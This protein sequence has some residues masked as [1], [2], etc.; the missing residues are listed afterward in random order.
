MKYR[1]SKKAQQILDHLKKVKRPLS[2]SSIAK[3]LG[4]NGETVRSLLGSLRQR[5]LIED[6]ETTHVEFYQ[7]TS[8]GQHFAAKGL[9]EIRL[10]KLLAKQGGEGS[11]ESIADEKILKPSEQQLAL[12]WARRNKW[13]SVSK[14]DNQTWMKLASKASYAINQHPLQIA[15]DS[16]EE[17][18]VLQLDDVNLERKD[19]RSIQL[20]LHK[21][22]LAELVSRQTI[23]VSITSKGLQALETSLIDEDLIRDLSP[24]L[25]KSEAWK[26]QDFMPYNLRAPTSPLYPGKKHPFVEFIDRLKRVL[27][28]LGFQEAKGPLVE[29]E[30]WN[31]D[32]LFMPQDHV[33]REV[34]DLYHIQTPKGPGRIIDESALKRVAKTHENGWKTGSTGWRYPYSF[35]IARR[36]VMRSQTTS[37]S[38]RFL[39]KHK[40]PPITM[41]SIDRNFRPEKFDATHS[42]EFIQ[43]EG[44]IG[45]EGLTLRDLM[46][47]LQSIA[48]GVGVEQLKFKP[49]FFP[50]T[51]PSVEGFVFI[52]KIGWKELGGSGI[53]RPEVTLPFGI[54]FPVLAWGLGADRLA[55][56]AL[57]ISDIRELATRN[58]GQ[59]RKT[60][61][62]F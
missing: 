31:N 46:G 17:S 32:A 16:A 2:V 61:M 56:A 5:K 8:E 22:K 6:K 59:L 29:T 35:D 15:L 19:L 45:G 3:S 28:G 47:Y 20:N 37:V 62:R 18:G 36:L 38:M 51:E 23:T 9:P 39:S 58:L 60:S 4:L 21:R 54:D 49:G 1:L 7:L 50:F 26:D 57:G 52:P 41:F 48:K 53:F 43:I 42:A 33:A 34:H 12:G 10:V 14:R 11:V 55:M 44:I 25:L 30:F 40:K 27:I 13:I 24:D